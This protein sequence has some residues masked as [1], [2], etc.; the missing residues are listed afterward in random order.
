MAGN[1]ALVDTL[2]H[3]P[4]FSQLREDDLSRISQDMR[5][6]SHPKNSIILFEDD[7]GDALYI[8]VKGKVKVVLTGEDGREVILSTRSDGDF[9]GEMSLIDSE[10]RSAHV[11]AMED[12]QLLVLRRDNFLQCLR[13]VP[14]ISFGV[15]RSLCERLRRADN[16]I[17]GLILMEVPERVALLLLEIAKENDEGLLV[18]EGV[19]HQTIAQMI[20]SSRETVSR[21]MRTMT[22][23]D[24]VETHR[25]KI[26]IKDADALASMAGTTRPQTSSA[27][28]VGAG[29]ASG[30]EE[31]FRRR[32][33]DVGSSS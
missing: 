22:D 19:T 3:I 32:A 14:G 21:A 17:G 23:R 28:A 6:R 33:T 24:I 7:E 15:M 20:G 29:K 4:L 2:R 18:A 13:D 10:P 11:V 12:C 1:K 16:L 26:V 25:K 8:I 9:F 27:T 31:I 5:E 30:A